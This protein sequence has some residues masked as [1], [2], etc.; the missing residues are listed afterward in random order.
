LTSQTSLRDA[1]QFVMRFE[2][3][4]GF[5]LAKKIVWGWMHLNEHPLQETLNLL[6]SKSLKRASC[7]RDAKLPS[8]YSVTRGFI[9]I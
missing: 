2:Q 6:N 3:V 9:V 1:N 8:N 5:I 4:Q 7:L